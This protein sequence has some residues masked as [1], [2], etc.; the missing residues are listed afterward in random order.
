MK[1]DYP[2]IILES[3]TTNP[4]GK[5]KLSQ[6][7]II[8]FVCEHGA[9]KSILAAAFFDRL[10]REKGLRFRAIARGTHPDSEISS[11]TIVG[12]KQD[13]LSPTQLTPA[14][15]T[16]EE[17]RSAQRIISFCELPKEYLQRVQVEQWLD[18]PP[19][20]ESYEQARD[21]II[22]RLQTVLVNL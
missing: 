21:A 12:L 13:G 10:A 20:S 1:V 8:I 2:G 19:V 4:E 11:K 9:A 18:I 6:D 3:L 14:K 17:M 16:W 22:A 7:S 15:L 5:K